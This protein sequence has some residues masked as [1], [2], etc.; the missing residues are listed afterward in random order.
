MNFERG[1][2]PKRAMEIGIRTWQNLSVGDILKCKPNKWVSID[3]TFGQ[4][5]GYAR[6]V[7]DGSKKTRWSGHSLMTYLKIV[8]IKREKVKKIEYLYVTFYNNDRKEFPGSSY[9][10]KR[11]MGPIER[12]QNNFI[13]LQ[14]S[15]L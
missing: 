15:E 11:L 3:E 10:Q 7:M 9:L 8:D 1:I 6:F 5:Y 4:T 13:I 12:F 14:S 2:D